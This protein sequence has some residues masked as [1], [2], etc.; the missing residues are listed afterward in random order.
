[1]FTEFLFT[2][3]AERKIHSTVDYKRAV[4]LNHGCPSS[5][6][7]DRGS[8]VDE[9]DTNKI[10]KSLFIIKCYSSAD[11]SQGN[12]FA[13]RNIRSIRET[14][15]TYLLEKPVAQRDWATYFDPLVFA[16]N[17]SLNSSTKF[18]PLKSCLGKS[19]PCQAISSLQ[20]LIKMT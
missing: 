12:G 18:T 8:N 20:H 2:K 3:C 6:L 14:I 10:Y 15:R 9:N 1:M 13:E 19:R 4:F 11:H 5:I 17:N 7:S 16:L